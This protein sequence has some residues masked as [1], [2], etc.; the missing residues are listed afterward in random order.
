MTTQTA[1]VSVKTMDITPAQAEKWL[2]G[3]VHNRTL[4]SNRVDQLKEAIDRGEWQF[5][6][7]PIRF[8]TD[9]VLLD[10]QH[11][12]WAIFLSGQTC[13]AVVIRG[14]DQESQ[15]VMDVGSRRSLAD[16][17]KLRKYPDPARLAAALNLKWKLDNNELRSAVKP[18]F[19]QALQVLDDHPDMTGSVS[20]CHTHRNHV[21]YG[22]TAPF[23]VM[24]YE[25]T[26]R[27]SDAAEA[28]FHG[29]VTGEDLH[30]GDPVYTLRRAL[31]TNER[32]SNPH[33]MAWMIKA[34][35]AYL[36]GVKMDR[37][38]WRPVGTRAEQFPTIK[39]GE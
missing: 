32:P 34:W 19:T 10:G 15:L 29:L 24:H 25:F 21:N 13:K 37:L 31:E 7:S 11:R 9:G 16:H 39:G 30:A 12:L 1:N 27:D 3:N 22:G 5:D 38:I 26:S 20:F 33:L 8:G 14:L 36:D 18:T 28:F 17:L 23:I 6:G 35:N 4:R 2:S